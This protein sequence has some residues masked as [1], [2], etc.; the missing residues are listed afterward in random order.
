MDGDLS[1]PQLIAAVAAGDRAALATLYDRHASTLMAV[2]M[3]MLGDRR[4]V[5][6]IVHDVFVEAW[7]AAGA[8]DPTRA[9]VRTWL[10]MRMRS[11]VLDRRKSAGVSRRVPMDPGRAERVAVFEDPS[12]GADRAVVR[13]VLATLPPEQRMV[14]EL[15]YF[16]GL[17][18]SE[19]AERART[20]IGTVKSRVAAALAKLRDGLAVERGG[21]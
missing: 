12:A 13:R 14:L 8:Y 20:P 9:S 7:R 16:E 21:Q 2:G 15:A 10:V 6:D 17:S 1:D 19:I 5:E 18:S 4:E 11:R 3:R